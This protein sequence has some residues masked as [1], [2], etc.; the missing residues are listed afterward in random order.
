MQGSAS[1][2]SLGATEGLIQH[3]TTTEQQI[4]ATT[5]AK[6]HDVYDSE[7]DNG[8]D[9]TQSGPPSWLKNDVVD[10]FFQRNV[11][12]LQN[13]DVASFDSIQLLDRV[14]KR[15]ISDK[16]NSYN[17]WKKEADVRLSPVV[18]A[19]TLS[20]ISYYLQQQQFVPSEPVLEKEKDACDEYRKALELQKK[21]SEYYKKKALTSS[22]A[23]RSPSSV[24]PSLKSPRTS[25][26]RKNKKTDK[27]AVSAVRSHSLV[28]AVGIKESEPEQR[29]EISSVLKVI[30]AL[31]FVSMFYNSNKL[32]IIKYQKDRNDASSAI[33]RRYRCYRVRKAL[34]RSLRIMIGFRCRRKILALKL[35]TQ[36]IIDRRQP[37]YRNYIRAYIAKIVAC[38]T[39]VRSVLAVSR[40]RR[41]ALQEYWKVLDVSVKRKLIEQDR[42]EEVKNT[43][44]GTTS[45]SPN[46]EMFVGGNGGGG[47]ESLR[48]KWMRRQ[49]K[50]RKFMKHLET[51]EF[52]TERAE[53]MFL[54]QEKQRKQKQGII[55]PEVDPSK[56]LAIP[57]GIL[58]MSQP[59]I[60]ESADAIG[61]RIKEKVGQTAG[62]TDTYAVASR[63]S[64]ISALSSPSFKADVNAT[65]TRSKTE[66]QRKSRE[67]F[68]QRNIILKRRL[69]VDWMDEIREEELLMKK[70]CNSHY[71]KQND[72][73]TMIINCS[74]VPYI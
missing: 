56:T 4:S 42:E 10:F 70:R 2:E 46:N 54:R 1:H 32:L 36:F 29:L 31:H 40:A 72:F 44:K 16:T 48:K 23:P 34:L 57:R 45:D 61:G 8:D 62:Q 12:R 6:V 38:Q 24:T 73:E 47:D 18:K 64:K 28:D 30:S 7:C 25:M 35:I 20:K 53:K 52:K 26:I 37:V 3:D 19:S 22:F 49:E 67:E 14:Q 60:G 74:D 41:I 50:I 15:R 43:T 21:V 27:N 13:S 17:R 65:S 63:I 69:L 11:S 68:L 55:A 59:F 9:G 39:I 33:G 5:G 51:V 58:P 71:I 66:I